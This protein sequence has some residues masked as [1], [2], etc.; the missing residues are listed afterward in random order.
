VFSEN[1]E[2]MIRPKLSAISWHVDFS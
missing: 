1:N 2:G